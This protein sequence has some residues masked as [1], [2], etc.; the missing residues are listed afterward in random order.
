M[1]IEQRQ[2][3]EAFKRDL[4]DRVVVV[5]GASAGI[6]AHL[7]GALSAR[8]AKIVATARRE[9]RLTDVLG[10]LNPDRAVA[11]RGDLTDEGFPKELM[12]AANSCFGRID[13]V[14]NNAGSTHAI[15]AEEESTEDFSRLLMINLVAVFACAREAFPYLAASGGSIINVASA[16]GLVGIGRIPQ[17]GYCAAKGG[18]ISLTRELAA[19]WAARGVRVNAVAPGWFPSEMTAAMFDAPGLEYIRRSVPMRRA[20]ELHELEGIV[21]FLASDES[22]YVTGQTFVVDGGWTSV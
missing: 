21:A 6:G 13:V 10:S 20:G 5:T 4:E 17:A 2:G 9:G 19:Q 15:P 22:S 14:L 1:R 7:V 12:E 16:L 3:G 11:V 8:G 18:V